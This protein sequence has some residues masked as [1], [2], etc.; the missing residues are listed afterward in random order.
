[1]CVLF[2]SPNLNSPSLFNAQLWGHS[3]NHSIM[4]SKERTFAQQQQKNIL[5]VKYVL[6]HLHSLHVYLCFPTI[7]TSF[8]STSRIEPE[9]KRK[10]HE[11]MSAEK[12]IVTLVYKTA[13]FFS[14]VFTVCARVT[15]E[16]SF[17]VCAV[18][19]NSQVFCGSFRFDVILACFDQSSNRCQIWGAF[20]IEVKHFPNASISMSRNSIGTSHKY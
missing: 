19:T 17:V 15:C 18:F 7:H 2:F 14:H 5:W 10:T 8:T 4:T 6:I 3:Y 13:C 1:M 20:E 12:L 16:R 9:E 11:C